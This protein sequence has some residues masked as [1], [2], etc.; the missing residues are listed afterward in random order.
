MPSISR[1]RFPR[2]AWL[3]L[4]AVAGG[5]VFCLVLRPWGLSA[6]ER[7]L[8][9]SWRIENP[10]DA[11]PG[12]RIAVFSPTGYCSGFIVEEATGERVGQMDPPVRWRVRGDQLI[13]DLPT[14]GLGSWISAATGFRRLFRNDPE[15]QILSLGPKEFSFKHAMGGVV[16]ARRLPS[17]QSYDLSGRLPTPRPVESSE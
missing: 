11:T 4:A 16:S 3:A 1:S 2:W 17:E 7:G 5:T 10:V 13:V 9:G 6:S 8:I 15:Y 12:T 14:S